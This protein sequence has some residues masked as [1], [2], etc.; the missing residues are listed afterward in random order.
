MKACQNHSAGD[1]A[2]WHR[3][4]N[5]LPLSHVLPTEG[6]IKDKCHREM[7]GI[8]RDRAHLNKR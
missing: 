2:Y 3:T 6:K 8:V 7:P 4:Y 1:L 5:K